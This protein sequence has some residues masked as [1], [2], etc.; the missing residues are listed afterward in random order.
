MKRVLIACFLFVYAS[1]VF[2]NESIIHHQYIVQYTNETAKK[3]FLDRKEIRGTKLD[4]LNSKLHIYLVTFDHSYTES[5]EVNILKTERGI[6]SFS[7]NKKLSS[8]TCKPNDPSYKDQWNMAFM[9]FDEAW[10]YDKGG[11]SPLGD[12]LAIGLIDFGFDYRVHD[13]NENLYRNRSEVEDNEMDD[14]GNGYIDDYLGFNAIAG[15]GDKHDTNMNHGTNVLSLISAKGNNNELITGTNLSIK[16]VI[17]SAENDAHLIKCYSY[18]IKL[19]SDYLNSNGKKGAFVVASSLSLGYD[20]D[21]VDQHP[22]LCE[23]YNQLGASGILN[24][25][26]TININANIDT[27]GDVPSLCP[28]P[29]LIAVTNTDRSDTKV[30]DAGYSKLN[31]DIAAS[32]ENVPVIA[33]GGLVQIQSGCSLSAPQVAGGIAYL[34]QYC[35]KFARLSK[36]DPPMA[37]LLMKNFILDGGKKIKALDAFT[38]SGNRF[39]V[40]GSL[41]EILK[42]CDIIISDEDQLDITPNPVTNEILQV[43]V[44][45]KTFKNYVLRISNT[46]GQVLYNQ[47]FEP[48]INGNHGKMIPV[49]SMVPGIYFLSLVTNENIVSKKFIKID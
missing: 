14:D 45:L 6:I 20:T 27:N 49:K 13:L 33:I 22:A 46:S 18:F 11:I 4:L 25:C 8:R 42:Y 24:V 2:G 21:F 7:A 17:C 23:I 30:I 40:F 10:C 26:A 1:N 12:T 41:Q 31:V 5:E 3:Q 28:S 35:E 34:N 44:D 15:K 32:G 48:G 39:D 47:T 37:A 43:D 19:R 36:T 9:G 38:L 16:T 29:Y